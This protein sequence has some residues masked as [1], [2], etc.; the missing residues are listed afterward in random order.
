MFLLNNTS[1]QYIYV[2]NTKIL[3]TWHRDIEHAVNAV[4]KNFSDG[5]LLLQEKRK[6]NKI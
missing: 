6:K 3:P 4:V 2:A 1:L 5:Y